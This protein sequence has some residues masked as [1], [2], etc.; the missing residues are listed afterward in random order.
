MDY[1]TDYFYRGYLLQ[2]GGLIIQPYLTAS[3]QWQADDG[4][5]VTPYVS[6]LS[7]FDLDG[8][9]LRML[10][11]GGHGHSGGAAAG[12]SRSN[13]F[14]MEL[15]GGAVARAGDL[16]ID[17]K[18]MLHE[19][20]GGSFAGV[21][22]LGAK[23]SYDIAPLWYDEA[24]S[25]ACGIKPFIAAYFETV[26]QEGTRDAYWE[27]GVEPYLRWNTD[28][29]RIGLSFPV[30]LGLGLDDYYFDARGNSESLGYMSFG[31]VASVPLSEAFEFA[32]VFLTASI[33][34]LHLFADN[35]AE[36]ASGRDQWVATVGIGFAF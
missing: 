9:E 17:F 26:D 28:R 23:I 8:T 16:S 10:P 31:A 36:I 6:L 20:S 5:S 15:F 32:S 4:I 18:Y 19:A 27:T 25:D 33:R 21:Q 35:L 11:S 2:S 14:E 30:I 13:W 29:C 3:W 24:S 22:E 7:S 34:Y 1:A 12:R